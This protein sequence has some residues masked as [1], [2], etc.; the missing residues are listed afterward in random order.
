MAR[1]KLPRRECDI[2]MKGGVT[3]GI[4]YP[5]A[6]LEL[7]E[8]YRFNSIGGTS[9]GAVAAAA[10]A[11]AEYGRQSGG[12]DRMREAA[13]LLSDGLMDRFG[14]PPQ[15]RPVV[16]LAK[17]MGYFGSPRGTKPGIPARITGAIGSLAVHDWRG[18]WPGALLGGLLGA[19][20]GLG[21]AALVTQP[22]GET[23]LWLLVV[24]LALVGALLGG[25]LGGLLDLL[26]R[27]VLREAPRNFYGIVNG[28]D[29]N[30]DPKRPALLTD[31]LTGE[32]DRI[33]GLEAA[34]ELLTFGHLC[35]RV[36]EHENT[37]EAAG[38]TLQMIAT[39]LNQGIPYRLPFKQR[40]FLFKRADVEKLFPERVVKHMV[41]RRYRSERL[42]DDLSGDPTSALLPP[43]YYF[44][45]VADDFPVVVAMRMSLAIPFF[46]SAV[47][48][49][50][51]K[52]SAFEKVTSRG[53]LA[54]DDLQLN[55]FSDGGIVSNFPIHSFD[56]WL[57]TRPTFG[58]TLAPM[59]AESLERV[60]RDALYEAFISVVTGDEVTGEEAGPADPA[61]L[62][63][64]AQKQM[65]EQ[66]MQTTSAAPPSR[67]GP[68]PPAV[69][70]A[71]AVPAVELGRPGRVVTTEWHPVDSP[72]SLLERVVS[73]AREN[74]DYLQSTL[75]GYRERIVKIR[76]NEDEGGMNLT[77]D[78]AAIEAIRQK[79][80]QA[81]LELA[82]GFNFDHHRWTRFLVLMSELEAQLHKMRAA[83][84]RGEYDDLLLERVGTQTQDVSQDFPYMDHHGKAWRRKALQCAQ[85]LVDV[86]DTWEQIEAGQQYEPLY[87]P[88]DPD[89][90]TGAPPTP[91]G[92][93]R[94]PDCDP[95][96]APLTTGLFNGKPGER[97][98]T[99]KPRPVL[100]VTPDF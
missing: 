24:P 53:R 29:P 61:E 82:R 12:F 59:P 51:I 57:P 96:A 89:E 30:P 16:E 49:Y 14:A 17:A 87:G 85:S 68:A 55:L 67:P 76:F 81:G 60:E 11:A 26:L 92:E 13:D 9:A 36:L 73:T 34:G 5:P 25:A 70:R 32:I 37:V 65:E 28:H 6:L 64:M 10:A 66:K 56:R 27:V 94:V 90:G 93:R 18:F 83:L 48:L 47:P 79:G 3:S 86:L 58:I 63:E 74:H 71:A 2:V 33:A 78:R 21:I 44:V 42:P 4:V 80:R 52:P 22:P 1:Q 99:P 38:I 72:F 39:N 40:T 69:P 91:L 62:A 20:L 77:M 98:Y 95:R 84:E 8:T 45:P 54:E 46:F 41:E 100:R 31:F 15:T 50:T 7:Q 23:L 19:L 35:R 43:G 75:P 88:H 97:D